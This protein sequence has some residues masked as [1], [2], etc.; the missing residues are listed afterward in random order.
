M[1]AGYSPWNSF[2]EGDIHLWCADLNHMNHL[3]DQLEVCECEKES[4]SQSKESIH[5]DRYLLRKGLTRLLISHYTSMKPKEILFKKGTLGKPVFDYPGLCFNVSESHGHFVI[6]FSAKGEIGV[7]IEPPRKLKG[8]DRIIRRF[9]SHEEKLEVK[10]AED[11]VHGFF[12]V[13]TRKEAFIK[14][15][16]KS[17]LELNKEENVIKKYNSDLYYGENGVYIKNVVTETH[18]IAV[19]FEH[20]NQRITMYNVE[21]LFI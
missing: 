10:G 2:Q 17:I 4:A 13:W 7:D 11:S 1:L 12:Q 16:G 6:A 8:Q 15:K 21:Q 18:I 3:V 5:R 20:I 19:A 9:F 14:Q